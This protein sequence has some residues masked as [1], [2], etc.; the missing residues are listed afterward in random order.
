MKGANQ[1][2]H[3][4]LSVT[5]LNASGVESLMTLQENAF[6]SL[7]SQNAKMDEGRS[8]VDPMRLCPH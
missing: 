6:I 3:D 2:W 4:L 5:Q 1:D 8:W 7:E